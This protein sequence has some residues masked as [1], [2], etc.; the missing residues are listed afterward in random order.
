[1]WGRRY[2]RRFIFFFRFYFQRSVRS[3]SVGIYFVRGSLFLDYL[4]S[5][6]SFFRDV[7]VSFTLLLCV[8]FR[9]FLISYAFPFLVLRYFSQVSAFRNLWYFR[10]NRL[11][12]IWARLIS[13]VHPEIECGL[14][15]LLKTAFWIA[16]WRALVICVVYFLISAGEMM[17]VLTFGR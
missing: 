14:R 8:A 1:M 10:F 16:F 6:Q 15:R 2:L 13:G 3:L 5:F 17:S 11:A 12:S 4:A 7:T 9:V